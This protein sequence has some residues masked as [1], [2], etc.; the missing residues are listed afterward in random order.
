M[1][2]LSWAVLNFVTGRRLDSGDFCLLQTQHRRAILRHDVET[3]LQLEV[4]QAI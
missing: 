2:A 1:F 4:A 3:V